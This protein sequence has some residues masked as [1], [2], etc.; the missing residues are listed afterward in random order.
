[1]LSAVLTLAVEKPINECMFRV[2][3][4][5]LGVVTEGV[6]FK[7]CTNYKLNSVM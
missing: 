1:M 7:A 3:D 4:G 5:K 6:N 2:T